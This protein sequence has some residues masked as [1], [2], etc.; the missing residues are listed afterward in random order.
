[1]SNQP[2][3]SLLFGAGIVT[4]VVM[5][6][7]GISAL[8]FALGMYLPLELNSPALIGGILSHFLTQRS[9]SMDAEPGRRLRERAV[10]IASGFMAGGALG[11]VLGAAFRLFP[12]YSEDFIRTPFYAHETI[13]QSLSIFCFA[14]L[15]AYLWFKAKGKVIEE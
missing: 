4:A 11:G 8:I 3:A 13:S 15:C 9:E 5:E 7:L 2:V 10:I 14:G 1:M 12:W 6:M